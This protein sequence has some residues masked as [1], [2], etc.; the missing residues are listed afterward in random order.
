M[1]NSTCVIAIVTGPCQN[2]AKPLDPPEINAYFARWMCM[3][4]LEWAVDADVPI[5]AVVHVDDKPNIGEL[6]KLQQHDGLDAEKLRSAKAKMLSVNVAHVDR[7]NAIMLD[8]SIRTVLAASPLGM[9]EQ[10]GTAGAGTASQGGNA[11]DADG[12]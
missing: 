9:S 12:R 4:E 3:K 1:K 10:K 7:S 8:A 2:P 11:H 5:Q 6:M